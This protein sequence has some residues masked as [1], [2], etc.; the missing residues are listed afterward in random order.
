M[1]A[2]T[3][4]GTPL[5]DFPDSHQISE[6]FHKNR[7][8]IN[9][10]TPSAPRH[11]RI[12]QFLT[13]SR[14][15][16]RF[17]TPHHDFHTPPCDFSR[18]FTFFSRFFTLPGH[19]NQC[20]FDRSDPEFVIYDLKSVEKVRFL[21]NFLQKFWGGNLRK[22]LI[23]TAAAQGTRKAHGTVRPNKKVTVARQPR[24]QLD[25]HRRLLKGGTTPW[26]NGLGG[27]KRERVR[28]G[29]RMAIKEKP[30]W[31]AALPL[32]DRISNSIPS[33]IIPRMSYMQYRQNTTLKD[34]SV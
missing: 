9:K 33:N 32:F 24:R 20:Y 10:I 21:Q 2:V 11:P 8:K 26:P 12:T 22:I 3:R 6:K 13:I 30:Y 4:G 14:S 29:R 27:W 31:A 16:S 5:H 7:T 15:N 28:R 25:P 18:F 34:Q 19:Q 23:I 17:L 1:E